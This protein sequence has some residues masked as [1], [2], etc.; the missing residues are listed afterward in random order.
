LSIREIHLLHVIED[1]IDRYQRKYGSKPRNVSNWNSTAYFQ[2]A[3][4]AA[5][6]T[7]G[8]PRVAAFDYLYPAEVPD[9][10]DVATK[11]GVPGDSDGLIV[12]SGTVATICVL[13]WL[14]VNGVTRVIVI[15]PAYWTVLHGARMLGLR[16]SVAFARRVNGAYELPKLRAQ[17]GTAIWTSNPYYSTGVRMQH[18]DVAALARLDSRGIYVVFDECL[19]LPGTEVSTALPVSPFRVNL[20]SPHKSVS[21]NFAKFAFLA[22]APG[23]RLS[24][25]SWAD[26]IFGGLGLGPATAIRHFLSAE[27]DSYVSRFRRV[28]VEYNNAI[29]CSVKGLA[30]EFDRDTAGNFISAYFPSLPARLGTNPAYLWRIAQTSGA[31]FIPNARNSFSPTVGLSFR[32]N[33]AAYDPGMASAFVRLCAAIVS[34]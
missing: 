3:V 18:K 6:G 12:P 20:Y 27:F 8:Y 4:A 21:L 22:F 5:D 34:R 13:N 2:E 15:G 16:V 11:I 30:V 32:V 31:I 33:L 14:R 29:Q 25:E 1:V 19:A 10:R 17:H 9:A 7:P 26:V 28:I 24:F 23:E